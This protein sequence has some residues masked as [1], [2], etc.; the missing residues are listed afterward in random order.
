MNRCVGETEVN[1]D[2]V[3]TNERIAP[4]AKAAAR[5]CDLQPG[6]GRE[7][8]GTVVSGTLVAFGGTNIPP[9]PVPNSGPSL[10][11]IIGA[12]GKIPLFIP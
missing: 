1:E 12:S 8:Q 6:T 4:G 9:N 2:A 10:V 11:S 5:R 7:P 3:E